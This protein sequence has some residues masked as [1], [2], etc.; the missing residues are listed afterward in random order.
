MA[1]P[2]GLYMEWASKKDG[3]VFYIPGTMLRHAMEIKQRDQYKPA[4]EKLRNGLI[5]SIE[6]LDNTDG[7]TVGADVVANL[8]IAMFGENSGRDA[9]YIRGLA[10]ETAILL[11]KA[12]DLNMVCRNLVDGATYVLDEDQLREYGL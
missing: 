12:A 5:H 7:Q 2:E 11:Q 8:M 6:L 10:E 3:P 9:L 1:T 4:L